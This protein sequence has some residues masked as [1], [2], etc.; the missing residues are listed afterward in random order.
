MKQG[1]IT[2]IQNP[3]NIR[4]CC[5]NT[6]AHPFE[7]IQESAVSMEDNGFIFLG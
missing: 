4:A 7:E 3:K 6:F 2:S 5:G 1:S